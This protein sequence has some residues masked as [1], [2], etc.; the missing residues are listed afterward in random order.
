MYNG[1]PLERTY[2]MN[3]YSVSQTTMTGLVNATLR[4]R[5]NAWLAEWV[6]DDCAEFPTLEVAV[7]LTEPAPSTVGPESESTAL[8]SDIM[9]EDADGGG[10]NGAPNNNQ[11][12]SHNNNNSQHPSNRHR[13]YSVPP[14]TATPDF[15]HFRQNP[16]TED[17]HA[18]SIYRQNL[19]SDFTDSALG[20]TEKSQRP[21]GNF[22]LRESTVQTILNHPKYGPRDRNS[23]LAAN[24]QTYL[25]FGLP[26]VHTLSSSGNGLAGGTN[27]RFTATANLIKDTS[28][29]YDSSEDG[30][31]K[32]TGGDTHLQ[33][34]AHDQLSTEQ[35]TAREQLCHESR[36]QRT[37]HRSGSEADLIQEDAQ[38]H[39]SSRWDTFQQPPK[40]NGINGMQNIPEGR[41][42]AMSHISASS[43]H[44][45]KL[46]FNRDSFY[47]SLPGGPDDEIGSLKHP[48]LQVRGL[49]FEVDRSSWGQK[50]CGRARTKL[51][52]LEGLS[53]EVRGGEILA[54]VATSENEGTTLLDI[55]SNRVQKRWGDK[56]RGE[57]LY[58][59]I[60]MEPE[61]LQNFVCYVGKDFELCPDMSV[62]QWM[63]FT[64]LVQEPGGPIRDTKERINALLEDLGLGQLRHTR[65][66]DLTESE[67]RRLNVATQLLLDTDIVLLDQPIQGMDILDSF[68]LIDYLRQWASRGRIVIITVHP[69]TYEIFTMM[70]RIAIVS[71]GR[72]V[73]FGRR[74]ELLDYFA[75][76]DFP[77]PPY[78]N[79][80]DYY[81][82]LVTL[83]NLSA[84]AMLESSQ[85]VENLVELYRRRND[86]HPSLSDPGPP[87]ITPHEVR[88]AGFFGQSLAL[89]IRAMI[90]TFPY[91]VV[92]FFRDLMLAALMSVLVG[93]V[94]W[95]VRA[96]REQEHV[97]DRYGF[98]HSLL[99]L[100]LWPML[101]NM[102][103]DVW[104]EKTFVCKD[105]HE[106]LY[107]GF[108][109]VVAKLTY[110]IPMSL[111]IM[112]AYVFPAYSMAGIPSQEHI[113][114]FLPFLGFMLLYLSLLRSAAMCFSL[115][116][117]RRH[118][119]ALLTAGLSS[120]FIFSGGWIVHLN[121]LS[122]FTQWLRHVSPLKWVMQE[123]TYH[124]FSSRRQVY[125]CPRNPVVLQ[126][127]GI[128][129]KADCA[130]PG[131]RHAVGLFYNEPSSLLHSVLV[132]LAFQL[133]FVLASILVVSCTKFNRA[134]NRMPRK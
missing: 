70:S 131:D 79:P 75:Y 118:I 98:Y 36:G 100:C 13:Q 106:K 83:D 61:K 33:A 53:F 94:F 17:L 26:R 2:A 23:E 74:R 101:L 54:V 126:E 102:I 130:W 122:Y 132:P 134:A 78:K 59:G 27:G 20:T 62:R 19:N 125:E 43:R 32:P 95:N 133:F 44:I 57:F 40:M 88:R 29:G 120:I 41:R 66:A 4:T 81:L 69:P 25:R 114:N 128:Q 71:T 47:N 89:W 64:S 22:Q 68:F 76:I 38:S 28:S 30:R 93:F 97:S 113:S 115:V 21:F 119:A 96:G 80:S 116:S 9:W 1:S 85:R 127:N 34:T 110:S 121:E 6:P 7:P 123:M 55:L 108:A 45:N 129:V 48:H 92:H 72:M 10:A 104:R 82:D 105:I 5:V 35:L 65:I 112:G 111:S 8:P 18:W 103:T 56:V 99:A 63:L 77:C 3:V 84:E 14:A 16:A 15:R 52:L 90:Y 51:L 46:P 107:S 42:S 73:Y 24:I 11:N 87:G 109:Y 50:L 37:P 12:N 49:T 60:L 91:N 67:K 58:N 86:D 31:R 124:E 117:A 39:R